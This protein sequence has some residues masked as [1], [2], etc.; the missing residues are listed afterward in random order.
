MR[1]QKARTWGIWL[2]ALLLPAIE[3]QSQEIAPKDSTN[4]VSTTDSLQQVVNQLNA[5]IQERD[6]AEL[7]RAIWKKRAK[8]LNIS[9]ITNQK[10]TAE[11]S[12]EEWKSKFGMA[13]TWGKTFYLHK[14]PLFRMLKFGLDWNW[15]EVSYANYKSHPENLNSESSTGPL[16]ADRSMEWEED[17]NEEYEEDEEDFEGFG[18][19]QIDIGM[20]IGPSIT[21]NPVDHLKIGTYFHFI[22]TFSGVIL[23]DEFNSGYVSNFSFGAAV[24]YKVISLG[25]ET[26]WGKGKYKNSLYEE[27]EKEEYEESSNEKI[28]LKTNSFRVYISFRF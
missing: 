16:P 3:L 17:W 13:I 15:S 24:A 27:D 10:L 12:G 2:I 25:F 14:K 23:N 9:Y 7:D 19:H 21:I 11:E 6:A 20:A 26:R 1:L 5:E 18:M 4:Q 22:P 28:K 8:Y